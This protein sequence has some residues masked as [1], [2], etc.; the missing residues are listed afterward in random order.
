M[1]IITE[2]RI[3]SLRDCHQTCINA[4]D[5]LLLLWY[6]CFHRSGMASYKLTWI[7]TRNLITNLKKYIFCLTINTYWV[8]VSFFLPY[9]HTVLHTLR[10]WEQTILLHELYS[11][12]SGRKFG[13][14][15]LWKRGWFWSLC[16]LYFLFF[17]QIT[18]DFF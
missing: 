14:Q 12:W 10:C 3:V 8:T 17:T 18:G 15:T 2:Y 4:I 1:R 11:L 7:Q 5:L 6:L 16:K 9:A 13:W